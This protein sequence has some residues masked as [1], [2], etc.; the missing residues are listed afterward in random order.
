MD[1][2]DEAELAA[3]YERALRAEKAGETDA[4][5][6]AYR[7]ML[8]LDPRDHGGAAV[9]LAGLGRGE[10]PARAPE[11]YVATLFDQHAEVFDTILVDSLGYGVPELVRN[12]LDRL[13]PGPYARMLDLGC[14]TGLAG[15]ALYDIAGHLTGVD[16][17]E[18]MIEMA[19]ERELYADLFLGEAVRFLEQANESWDLIVATDVLPYLGGVEALFSGAAVRLESGGLFCFST[20]SLPADVMGNRPFMVGTK[21]RFAHAETYL[22]V[23]LASAGFYL[24]AIEPIVVRH[25]EGVPVPGQL[26]LARRRG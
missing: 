4:A 23:A 2:F 24:V 8:R 19:H 5:A 11:A 9:R 7:E 3:V 22:R 12:I 14:G 13:A 6:S 18:K 17:S 15:E 16:L 26:V 21:Q 20:E 1:D 10:T 25:E